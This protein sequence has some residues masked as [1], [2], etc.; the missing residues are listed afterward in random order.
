MWAAWCRNKG[1]RTRCAVET[2]KQSSER[3]RKRR[4]RDRARRAVQTDSER[5]A[6]LQRKST[7]ECEGWRM[8]PLRRG[9]RRLQ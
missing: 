1:D 5:Q 3:L 9:E 2:A 8:G 7:R 4:E 6:A